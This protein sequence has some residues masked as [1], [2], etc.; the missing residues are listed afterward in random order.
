MDIFP[1][2]KTND[3]LSPSQASGASGV[4]PGHQHLDRERDLLLKGYRLSSR[5][6][7]HGGFLRGFVVAVVYVRQRL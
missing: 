3:T 5:V 1:Q 2:L 7:S 6:L 4:T